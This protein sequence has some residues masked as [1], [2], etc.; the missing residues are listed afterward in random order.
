MMDLATL[1]GAQLVATGAKH[2]AILSN[3]EEFQSLV[4]RAGQTSGDWTF[5]ILYAPELVG[6]DS[7]S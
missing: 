3:D 5:P 2:A 1:T 6:I 7:L 4:H